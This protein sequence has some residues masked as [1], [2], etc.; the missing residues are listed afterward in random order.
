MGRT[1]TIILILLSFLWP[2]M[3]AGQGFMHRR[4]W[5]PRP[6]EDWIKRLNL[7]E[8]QTRQI[9]ALRDAY[10][11]DTLSWRDELTAKRF[12]L[13]DLLRDPQADPNRV[14]AVQR[15]VSDL[16]SRIEERTV[17][18]QLELRKVLTPEQ[19]QMLPPGYGGGGFPGPGMMRGGGRGMRY[20]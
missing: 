12:H 2:G 19:I 15:E 14:L 16:E 6:M 7:S 8:E 10:R 11:R 20:E 1:L 13:R 17:I 9:Q 3:A 4:G 18:F 5:G